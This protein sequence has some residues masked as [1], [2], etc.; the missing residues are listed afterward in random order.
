[1][2]NPHKRGLN[3]TKRIERAPLWSSE[4]R[5]RESRNLTKRIEREAEPMNTALRFPMP[6][7]SQRELK[8]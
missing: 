1:M 2:Q 3:L 6:G 8:A 7:I 5:R 4:S